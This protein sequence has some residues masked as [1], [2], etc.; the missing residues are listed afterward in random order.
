AGRGSERQGA[1]AA[2]QEGI[3]LVVR[4]VRPVA[5]VPEL[6]PVL[7]TGAA[8]EGTEERMAMPT[9]AAEPVVDEDEYN[10]M[11]A[12]RAVSTRAREGSGVMRLFSRPRLGF[13]AIT[14]HVRKPVPGGVPR[15]ERACQLTW[16]AFYQEIG[17]EPGRW[18]TTIDGE[19]PQVTL[20]PGDS[21]RIASFVQRALAPH[22][23]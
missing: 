4:S 23:E 16:W 14:A 17:A 6:L 15:W 18:L 21:R 2:H 1:V 10:P 7:P 12:A 3:A 8:G 20:H 13:G 5:V 11:A 9:P 19:P 22:L